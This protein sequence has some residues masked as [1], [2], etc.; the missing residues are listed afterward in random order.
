MGIRFADLTP[1]DRERIVESI[2]SPSH[3]REDVLR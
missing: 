1:A 3:L 2:L